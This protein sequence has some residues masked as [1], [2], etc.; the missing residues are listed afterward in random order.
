MIESRSSLITPPGDPSYSNPHMSFGLR[1]QTAVNKDW[2]VIF[3]KVILAPKF[4]LMDI[5][6]LPFFCQGL[7]KSKYLIVK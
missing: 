4:G 2:A 3:S 5:T 1:R 6:Y 7:L